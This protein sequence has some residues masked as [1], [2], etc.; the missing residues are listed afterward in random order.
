MTKEKA[1]TRKATNISEARRKAMVRSRHHT[2][3]RS[4]RGVAAFFKNLEASPIDRKYELLIVEK[5]VGGGRFEVKD[6]HGIPRKTKV[7]IVR[8]LFLPGRL[9]EK[10]E[11][12]AAIGH[13]SHVV[14]RD[15]M[16]EGVLSRKEVL[17]AR[18]L[19]GVRESGARV[20]PEGFDFEVNMKE[21]NES[22]GSRSRSRSGSR[23]RKG[24]AKNNNASG[25]NIN[26]YKGV[27]KED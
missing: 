14:V 22:S 24:A 18:R 5:P 2:Q 21:K 6:L 23:G 25:A 7:G 17:Q 1:V 27:N 8:G 10:A 15:D 13:G 12:G 9:H 26:L 4:N 20:A 11:M 16:I 3:K 19:L